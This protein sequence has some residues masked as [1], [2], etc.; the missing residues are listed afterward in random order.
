MRVISF[1]T[2]KGGSGKTTLALC[3]AVAAEEVGK[4][5]LIMDLDPQGTAETWYQDREQETP[6]LVKIEAPSLDDA[7]SRAQ[8]SGFDLVLI[9]TPGRDEPSSA[10][11]IRR[12]DLCI[13]P[14]RPTPA[15]MKATPST[16]GTINRLT[17][18]AAFVLTQTPPRGYRIRE[19]EKGLSVLGMVAPVHTVMRMA[20]QDAQ[21]LGLGVTEYE[22]DGK[23]AQEVREI[24]GWIAT[25]LEKVAHGKETHIA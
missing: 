17:K 22:S 14:C 23:A 7:I 5:V 21:S 25:K 11:A 8:T 3:C 6:R 16:I 13:I 20:Y 2:Q 1:I 18:P 10:A 19:A 24:W 15:D 9:D 12:S 4:R